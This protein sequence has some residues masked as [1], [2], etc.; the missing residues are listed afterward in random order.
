MCTP[1]SQLRKWMLLSSEEGMVSGDYVFIFVDPDLPTEHTTDYLTSESLWKLQDGR[2]EEAYQ[3]FK[4]VIMVSKA[5]N[6]F[7]LMGQ[8]HNIISWP[9]KIMKISIVLKG[10]DCPLSL[11]SVYTGPYLSQNQNIF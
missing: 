6:F 5:I 4:N 1:R 10:N 2:D 9:F 11:L 7:D 8:I 3:A